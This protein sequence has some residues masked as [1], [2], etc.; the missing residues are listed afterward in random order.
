MSDETQNRR[1]MRLSVRILLIASLGLNLIVVGLIGGAILRHG[2]KGRPPHMS[3]EGPGSPIVRALAKDER[4]E[5][6][7]SIRSAHRAHRPDRDVDKA[8]YN[9]LVVALA[10]DPYDPDAVRRA[11]EGLDSAHGDRRQ[12]ALGIWFNYVDAMSLEQRKDYA[13][14]LEE[15]L[16]DHKWDRKKAPRQD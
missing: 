6:G 2:D 3:A 9:V 14:R 12:I 7:K 11:R 13:A 4:R 10:A 8:G 16:K 15:V 5:I 1:N